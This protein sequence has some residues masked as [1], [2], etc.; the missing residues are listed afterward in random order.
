M[1][2]KPLVGIIMGSDSDLDIMGEAAETLEELGIACEVDVRSAHRTPNETAEYVKTAAKRGLKVII[3]GAGKSAHLAG[4]T[5]A[6][7]MLPVL[8]IPVKRPGDGDVAMKSNAEMPPGVPL[9]VMP[10]NGGKNAGLFAAEILA[11]S[12]D[13][14]RQKL[15]EYRQKQTAKT[16]EKSKLMRKIGWRKYLDE[17]K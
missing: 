9:A 4:V 11:L 17:Q 3:A 16:V 8:A 2:G 15:S 5:A 1:A 13:K 10:T 12:D 14:I 6:N 7:T